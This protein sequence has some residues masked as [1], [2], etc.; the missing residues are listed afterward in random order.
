MPK[1]TKYQNSKRVND[2][3]QS[4]IIRKNV[5]PQKAV[6]IVQDLGFNTY[7][8]DVTKNFYRFRQFNPGLKKNPKYL[9]PM[10][11]LKYYLST[12]NANEK[13]MEWIEEYLLVYN[14]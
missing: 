12:K 6:K 5:T 3:V 13:D 4:I 8:I 14:E 9:E 10:I 2:V 11:K 1:L 7:D